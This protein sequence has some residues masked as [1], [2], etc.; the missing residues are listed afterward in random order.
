MKPKINRKTDAAESQPFD[1]CN[2]PAYALDP[3]LPYLRRAWH[4]WESAA[5]TKNLVT[6]LESRGYAVTGSD[7]LDGRSFFDYQPPHFDAIVTNPPYSIKFDWLERCYAL[8]KPFALLV[9]VEMIGAQAAQRLMERHGCELLLLNRR[10]NFEMP[11]KGWDGSSAQFPV[12]WLCWRML[13]TPIVYGKLTQRHA[14]QAMMELPIVRT[15]A[16]ACAICHTPIT[17]PATGRPRKY[18]QDCAAG[19]G[20]RTPA[21]AARKSSAENVT[22]EAA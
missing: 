9:P 11:N 21:T 19:L 2:T 18:C 10:V 12:L 15:A 6:A 3:L 22:E 1:R 4:I 16:T 17:Q 7:I 13:P 14:G 20:H 5:G 8:G